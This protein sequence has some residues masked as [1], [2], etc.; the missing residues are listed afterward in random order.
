MTVTKNLFPLYRPGFCFDKNDLNI[1]P[2]GEMSGS[3]VREKN[4]VCLFLSLHAIED[5]CAEHMLGLIQYLELI[6]KRVAL[7]VPE[8]VGEIESLAKRT[9]ASLVVGEGSFENAQ[10]MSRMMDRSTHFFN[11][12]SSF[13]MERG[14]DLLKEWGYDARNLECLMQLL[15]PKAYASAEQFYP[16]PEQQRERNSCYHK[17]LSYNLYIL[18]KTCINEGF[19]IGEI[20]TS[21]AEKMLERLLEDRHS[22]LGAYLLSENVDLPLLEVEK[23]LSC[24]LSRVGTSE[25]NRACIEL[26]K[27]YKQGNLKAGYFLI[28]LIK[29]SAGCIFKMP[30]HHEVD[31]STLPSLVEKQCIDGLMDKPLL[32]IDLIL[33]GKIYE[34]LLFGRELFI[35]FVMN[36]FEDFAVL[37]LLF[38]P[39]SSK[40]KL[41][42]AMQS[43]VSQRPLLHSFGV[44]AKSVLESS[45]FTAALPHCYQLQEIFPQ[46]GEEEF[47]QLFRVP[48][49]PFRDSSTHNQTIIKVNV[50]PD[51]FLC[52]QGPLI[53]SVHCSY[54]KLPP[55]LIAFDRVKEK[56]VWGIA[57]DDHD[58]GSIRRTG[59]TISI[60]NHT[61]A[62]FDIFSLKDGIKKTQFSHPQ[63][64]NH[65]ASPSCYSSA[66]EIC[67]FARN[68]DRKLYIERQTP[69]ELNS[70]E[71]K[72][73]NHGK[74]IGLSTH[75]GVFEFA[76]YYRWFPSRV[77]G[78]LGP[79]GGYIKLHKCLDAYAKGDKLFLINKSDKGVLLLDVKTLLPTKE[80]FADT[81]YQ[82][83]FEHMRGLSIQML[84]DN[85]DLLLFC[86][87]G[88]NSF[89]TIFVN[90]PENRVVMGSP[91]DIPV[92]APYVLDEK[93]GEVWVHHQ[94]EKKIVVISSTGK[95]EIH[96]LPFLRTFLF[97]DE[98]D[99]IYLGRH[100]DVLKWRWNHEFD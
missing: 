22:V 83:V 15:R 34:E 84:C 88:Y 62:C 56:M 67:Y 10:E 54:W 91:D 98:E 90:I 86:Q 74:L 57:L 69:G 68:H 32:F 21:V 38:A 99:R 35:Q 77:H 23:R 42:L 50:N 17:K 85:G 27:E 51:R 13:T 20:E 26:C 81:S 53:I 80:V 28:W 76:H 46:Y 70:F 92:K 14:Y 7:I 12:T 8:R 6:G 52:E 78:I 73:K 33:K 63:P 2:L 82:Q 41:R 44:K 100:T 43:I 19:P 47:F 25:V 1:G 24:F 29:H 3:S 11:L 31:V 16:R 49:P 72:M 48:L 18:H 71:Y 61:T 37:P 87:G 30:A 60:R 93:R 40:H 95:R 5:S 45:N 55:Y 89:K 96:S 94:A 58:R 79:K 9:L 97:A 36:R 66:E 4:I 75:C 65:N 59:D 64:W 39:L